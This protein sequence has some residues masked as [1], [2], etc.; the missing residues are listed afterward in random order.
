MSGPQEKSWEEKVLLKRENGVA[1]VTLN[2]PEVLN[3]CDIGMLKRLQQVMKDVEQDKSVR[4][5]VLTGSGRAFCAGADLQSLKSRGSSSELSLAED[6]K[7]GFNPAVLRIRNMD[8]PVIAM[9]N[10]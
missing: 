7:E 4:C 10:G 6:L 2:R 3:A 5:V 1:W 8:K 9:V